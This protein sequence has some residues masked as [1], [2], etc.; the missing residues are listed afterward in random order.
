MSKRLRFFWHL[1]TA[2]I[3]K[4]IKILSIIFVLLIP[5]IFLLRPIVNANNKFFLNFLKPNYTEGVVGSVRTINPLFAENEAERLVNSLVFRGLIR[6]DS[7]GNILPDLAKEFEVKNKTEYIFHL[8]TDIY[9][10]DGKKFTSGDVV[11][12]IKTAQNP[13]L[14]STISGTFR[15]VEVSSEDSHTVKMKLM[16]PFA[17]FLSNLN[18]GIIPS[19]IPLKDYRP[20]GTGNFKVKKLTN[21]RVILEGDKLKITFK[22]YPN[23]E[24]AKLALKLGEVEGLGG[25]TGRDIEEFKDRVD[26]A[27]YKKTLKR[28]FIAAFFNLRKPLLKDKG[29]RDSLTAAINKEEILKTVAGTGSKLAVSSL[30]LNWQDESQYNKKLDFNLADSKKTLLQNGWKYKD[31]SLEKNGE[32]FS[33]N[34]VVPDEKELIL[35]SDVIKE[36]WKKLGIQTS[37]RIVSSVELKEQILPSRQYD[38]LISSQVLSSDPDQY[39]LW[40]STQT[41]LNNL[42]GLQSAKIDK[43]LEDA[44]TNLNLDQ[45][46]VKYNEF[47]RITLDERPAIFLYFPEYNWLVKKKLSGIDLSDFASS[48]DRFD[49]ANTWLLK[50]EIF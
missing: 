34:I 32:T 7:N 22:F 18:I 19:H 9:W 47:Q 12:T 23:T 30:P 46:K 41:D 36:N 29:I 33:L 44:R 14:H 27:T 31:R 5:I 40:H 11:H 3:S 43:L 37:L 26:L 10:H 17:P 49:S 20:V 24:F 25:L 6:V 45:R 8:R 21:D 4:N 39:V 1:S 50:R 38:V 48:E 16:E 13:D 15:G 28:Q 42:T 2:L 35:I